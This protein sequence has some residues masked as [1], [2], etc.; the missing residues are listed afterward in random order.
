MGK[1]GMGEGKIHAGQLHKDRQQMS[2]N[3]NMPNVKISK[4]NTIFDK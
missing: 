3:K 1:P 2:V 4:K